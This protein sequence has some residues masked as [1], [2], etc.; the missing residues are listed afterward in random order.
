MLPRTYYDKGPRAL[1]DTITR[2]LEAKGLGSAKLQ[3]VRKGIPGRSSRIYTHVDGENLAKQQHTATLAINLSM[4]KFLFDNGIILLK[5][6]CV[7]A[8]SD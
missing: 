6:N 3:S 7:L 8:D 4:T 2:S 5:I 1:K